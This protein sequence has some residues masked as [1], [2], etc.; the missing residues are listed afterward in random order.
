MTGD[1]DDPIDAAEATWPTQ[2]QQNL[3]ALFEPRGVVVVGASPHRSRAGGR[4][5]RHLVDAGYQ[6]TVWG[7]NPKYRVIAGRKA[8]PRVRDVPDGVDLAVICVPAEH[9]LSVLDDCAERGIRAA[10]LHADGFGR[11]WTSGPGLVLEQARVRCALR[12]LGPNTNGLRI[13]TS[14]MFADASTGLA[15]DPNV[16]SS[17]AV[18]TQSGGLA[19]YFGWSFLQKRGVGTK[20]LIDSGNEIDVDASDCIEYV[21]NDP[22]INAIGLILESLKDGR[23]LAEATRIAVD[24]GKTVV[25]LHVATGTASR[26]AAATHSGAVAGRVDVFRQVMTDAGA[27]VCHGTRQFADA[28]AISGAGRMPAGRRLGVVSTSGGFGV[29]AADIAERSGLVLPELAEEPSEEFKVEFPNA[30]FANPFDMAPQHRRPTS[31]MARGIGF[32][33]RQPNIDMV[34]SWQHHVLLNPRRSPG[35]VAGLVAAARRCGKPL[36]VCGATTADIRAELWRRGGIMSFDSPDD[37]VQALGLLVGGEFGG[38]T[39]EAA[40]NGAPPVEVAP[41]PSRVVVGDEAHAAMKG[42]GIEFVR[43]EPVDSAAE[44]RALARGAGSIMLKLQVPGQAHKTE[45]GHVL[46]PL[47]PDEIAAAFDR[48]RADQEEQPDGVIVAEPYVEGVELAIGSVQDPSFGRLVMAGAGGQLVELLADVGFAAAP[49][50]EAAARAMLTRLRI[51]PLLTG[52]RGR[53]AADVDALVA[54]IV[55]LSQWI[56]RPDFDFDEVDLNP[57]IV[58]PAGRGAVAVD[59]ALTARQPAV[60]HSLT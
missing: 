52:H 19:T 10:V 33:A 21:S 60:A 1:L 49:T 3:D 41:D 45:L 18:V 14:G 48:L 50:T 39:T 51:Y 17:V 4:V 9:V 53:P 35:V 58:R 28:L 57:V 29:L 6:G 56:S 59:C 5:I 36:F 25:V 15:V 26:R 38:E 42:S 43:S 30:T 2:R 55:S 31:T 8:F 13:A 47:P 27:K 46:G 37:A 20:Y 24:R 11:S 44:A 23:R 16:A 7:V 54:A 40:P 34:L 12:I 32:L 22:D